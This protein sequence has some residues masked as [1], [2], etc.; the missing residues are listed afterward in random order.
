M[1]F[2]KTLL[3]NKS[4]LFREGLKTFL[5]S[6]PMPVESEAADLKDALS[7][8]RGGVRPELVIF[9][10]TENDFS[11]LDIVRQLGRLAPNAKLALL[12]GDISTNK[13]QQALDA[14]VDGCL[15]RDISPEALIH[16]IGLIMA[17]ERA[18]PAEL[19]RMLFARH[20]SAEDDQGGTSNNGLSRREAEILGCLVNGDP[21]KV[22]ARRLE[23]SEATVKVHLKTILRKINVANRTQAAM[24]AL[25]N[26]IGCPKDMSAQAMGQAAG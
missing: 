14:G 11:H 6:S 20:I 9:D 2:I 1:R 10:F 8:V 22:I 15:A 23:I 3:V 19:A 17:G 26:G 7:L 18:F 16:Y 21:N 12:T 4:R 24:W 5:V 13:L 25:Q